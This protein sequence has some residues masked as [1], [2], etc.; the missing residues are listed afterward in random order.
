MPIFDDGKPSFEGDEMVIS[1]YRWALDLTLPPHPDRLNVLRNFAVHL[2]N[3]FQQRGD[4]QDLDKAISIN[5]EVLTLGPPPNPKSVGTLNN[6]GVA[7]WTRFQHC[8]NSQDLEESVSLLRLAVEYKSLGSDPSLPVGNLAVALWLRY[9]FRVDA[10]DLNECILLNKESLKLRPPSHPGRPEAFSNLG[11]GLWTR[12]K[13]DGDARSLNESI[14]FHRQATKLFP[15]TNRAGSLNNLA[16][17]LMSRFEGQGDAQD[18]D[19][20]ISSHRRALELRPLPHPKR[21]LSMQNLALALSMRYERGGGTHDLEESILFRRQALQ[22]EPRS[23]PGRPISLES[24]AKVLFLKYKQCGNA[25]YL[26]ESM[27]FFSEATHSISQSPSQRFRRA[28]SWAHFANISQHQSAIEAFDVA[29][30]ILPELAALSLDMRSRQESLTYETDGLVREAAGCAIRVG[31]L[32]KAVEFLEAGRSV[33]W[34]QFLTLRSP[35]DQLDDVA[36][37]LAE[38]LRTISKELEMASHRDKPTED[39]QNRQRLSWEL[40]A[41]RFEQ[42]AKQWKEVVDGVRYLDGFEDFLRP[43]RLAKLQNAAK[44]GPVIFLVAN[45]DASNCLIITSTQVHH[46]PLPNLTNPVL[47]ALVKIVQAAVSDEPILRSFTEEMA[48]IQPNSSNPILADL[49]HWIDEEEARGM[50]LKQLIPGL[51]SDYH[52]RGILRILWDEA[53]KSIVNFLDL[54][55]NSKGLF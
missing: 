3:Q 32:I 42:L 55:V 30:G 33:F 13:K 39:M 36:P 37:E 16:L 45:N 22:L 8:G 11:L 26:E 20:A 54:K 52:F 50:R 24:F 28:R 14:F 18:L 12:F 29:L 40:E 5:R 23:H 9:M 47:L 53:V 2:Y 19:E 48:K 46:I 38:D 21:A 4:I 6:I 43:P 1:F 25:S 49:Q 35:L 27:E 51:A 41:Q 10:Q 31:S 15:I 44:R 17:A 34:S 7:L